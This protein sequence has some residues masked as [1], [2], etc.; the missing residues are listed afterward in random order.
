LID[1]WR[2][3]ARRLIDGRFCLSWRNENG[4]I[5]SR[6]VRVNAARRCFALRVTAR[7]FIGSAADV[8]SRTTAYFL[9]RWPGTRRTPRLLR[10]L[11]DLLVQRIGV[12]LAALRLHKKIF[13]K[14]SPP[15]F[16]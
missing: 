6:Q 3:S 12:V 13:T 4:R 10:A 16:Q 8:S 2:R 14:A 5:G 15:R 11:S 1:V 9:R 7:C